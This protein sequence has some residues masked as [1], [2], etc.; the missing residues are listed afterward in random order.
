MKL[1]KIM[2]A[3]KKVWAMIEGDAAR[4]LDGAP[5]DGI[6]PTDETVKLSDARLLAPCEPTKIVA[7]GKNYYDHVSEMN[8]GLPE[9]PIIFIKPTTALNDPDGEIVCP[10]I[11]ARVDYEGELALVVKKKAYKVKK[12]DAADYILGYTCLN[13]VTARDL[14]K[15]DGQWTRGK[16]FDTFAPVGPL[17]TDEVN[18]EA[19]SI[20]T[21]LN[22]EVKQRSD[23][24]KLM[25]KIPYLIEFI[26]ACMTLLPGDVVTTGT[27]AGI[28]PMRPGDTV[29]VE[30]EGIGILRNRIL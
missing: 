1:V 26:T 3:G 11:S 19:L 5:F 27:P 22:G 25:W 9:D 23:T 10:E 28:G 29:E 6:S 21:R 4:F 8:D 20:E 24:G 7:I 2:H 17:L 18:P 16:G 14:Q 13:D 15:K 30:I 12:E